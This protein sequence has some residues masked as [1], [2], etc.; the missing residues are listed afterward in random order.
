MLKSERIETPVILE[1]SKREELLMK[2]ITFEKIHIDTLIESCKL[3]P[4][5]VSAALIQ[6]ELK[7]LIWQ[8]E[9]KR[10]VS[11]FP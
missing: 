6:L 7:G 10:F 3:S 2:H 8:L 1:L 4:G 11:N 5:E 9:G